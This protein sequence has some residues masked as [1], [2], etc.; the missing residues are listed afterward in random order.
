M[1]DSRQTAQIQLSSKVNQHIWVVTRPLGQADALI[2]AL[3]QVGQQLGIELIVSHQPLLQI[4]ACSF[5]LPDLS[6]IDGV[7]A[8]SPNAVAHFFNSP[9]VDGNFTP[10]TA[11]Q[12][13]YATSNTA[14]DSK[15][16]PLEIAY[17]SCQHVKYWLAVGEKTASSLQQH[18]SQ[19]VIS[20]LQMNSEGL[21]NLP[22]LQAVAGQSWLIIKGVGGRN[23]LSQTL[24][25]RGAK[26]LTLDVYQRKLPDFTSQKA[27]IEQQKQHPIW[28][29]TSYEA[30]ENLYRILGLSSDYLHRTPI[31][32]SSERLKQLALQ[33]GFTIV[34][35]SAGASHTQLVQCVKEYLESYLGE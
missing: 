17:E 12:E 14:K 29:V 11:D 23:T 6:N 24:Q 16:I 7:I 26:V 30:L 10:H 25:Q 35:V 21:L 19:S 33:K 13:V 27:I 8:I 31:V 5:Q 15:S 34:A 32:V 2:T 20:P 1:S 18:I 9:L 3:Q 28:I 22:E 4:E